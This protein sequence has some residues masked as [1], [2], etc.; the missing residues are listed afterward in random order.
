MKIYRNEK[1]MP[2]GELNK[3]KEIV[4][5]LV[6]NGTRRHVISYDNNGQHCNVKNCEINKNNS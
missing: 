6:C 4:H 1:D 2:F 3:D 5:H